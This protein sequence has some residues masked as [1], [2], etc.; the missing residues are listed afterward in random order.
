MNIQRSTILRTVFCKS[1]RANALFVAP[2]IRQ[3]TKNGTT[4]EERAAKS[5]HTTPFVAAGNSDMRTVAYKRIQT[6]G[7]RLRVRSTYIYQ[8]SVVLTSILGGHSNGTANCSVHTMREALTPTNIDFRCG[9]G[10][11]SGVRRHSA[12]N[13]VTERTEHPP[14]TSCTT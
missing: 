13:D 2:S 9:S 1:V 6:S 14:I 11:G 4:A 10:D 8:Q 12:M 5:E 3:S 7:V